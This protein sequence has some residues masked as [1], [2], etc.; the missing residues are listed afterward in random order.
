MA[1]AAEGATNSP[2]PDVAAAAEQADARRPHLAASAP[3]LDN[4]YAPLLHK[5]LEERQSPAGDADGAAQSLPLSDESSSL[6]HQLIQDMSQDI[7][8]EEEEQRRRELVTR[9]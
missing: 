1:A 5:R 3:A 7:R 2:P 8:I 4:F 9:A 6:R